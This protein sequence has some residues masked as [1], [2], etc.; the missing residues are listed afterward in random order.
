MSRMSTHDSAQ[1]LE[2]LERLAALPRRTLLLP[3]HGG[4]FTDGP[5]AAVIRARATGVR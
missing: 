4:P 5:R 2:S 3:G 1:A